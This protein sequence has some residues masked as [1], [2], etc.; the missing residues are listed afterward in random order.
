MAVV[1]VVVVVVTVDFLV[2]CCSFSGFD[3]VGKLFR[4][5]ESGA[6]LGALA[7]SHFL[8]ALLSTF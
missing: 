6:R 4:L 1:S 2:D 7:C 5:N 8:P 3:R